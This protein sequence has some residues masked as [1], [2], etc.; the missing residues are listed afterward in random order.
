MAHFRRLDRSGRLRGEITSDRAL[1]LFRDDNL[2]DVASDTRSL[3]LLEVMN[4]KIPAG[5]A[6]RDRAA[7]EL[8]NAKTAIALALTGG[9]RELAALYAEWN[10]EALEPFGAAQC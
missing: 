5:L 6:E 8:V 7:L 3:E 10:R 2:P 9:H 1:D 4:D